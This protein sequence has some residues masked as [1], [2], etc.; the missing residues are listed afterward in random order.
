MASNSPAPAST[1]SKGKDNRP[2]IDRAW[3]A[4]NPEAYKEL[5]KHPEQCPICMEDL[6]S[7]DNRPDSANSPLLGE[8]ASKCTHF[9]CNS[10]WSEIWL[11]DQRSAKCPVCRT[12]LY[13]WMQ[14]CYDRPAVTMREYG[15]FIIQALVFMQGREECKVAVEQGMSIMQRM[16]WP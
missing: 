11:R 2:F 8:V 10:C 4:D 13:R 7:E 9:A 3:V 16:R 6:C 5:L 1:D 14:N 15:V 12:N